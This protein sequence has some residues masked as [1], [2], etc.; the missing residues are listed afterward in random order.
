MRTTIQLALSASAA[1]ILRAVRVDAAEVRTAYA[2]SAEHLRIDLRNQI[3]ASSMAH[4]EPARSLN[5][6][7]AF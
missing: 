2:P 1:E 6:I 3:R 5:L 4:I 7:Q